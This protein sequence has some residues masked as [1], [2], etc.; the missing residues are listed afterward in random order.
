[1]HLSDYEGWI[2]GHQWSW[3]Q[4]KKNPLKT[5][6]Q[7]FRSHT[8]TCPWWLPSP[9]P[10]HPLRKCSSHC[11]SCKGW[12]SVP[13]ICLRIVRRLRCRPAGTLGWQL[14]SRHQASSWRC[15][16]FGKLPGVEE[17]TPQGHRRTCAIRRHQAWSHTNLSFFSVIYLRR[18]ELAEK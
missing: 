1:M 8:G 18:G 6:M 5:I 11:A 4:R 3:Q 2:K 7:S 17:A 15:C 14:S 13:N 16:V 9:E 10:W 12:P